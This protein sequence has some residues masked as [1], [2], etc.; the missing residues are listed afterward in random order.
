MGD[1]S[2]EARKVVALIVAAGSSQRF[3][4]DKLW[5]PVAGQPLLAHTL[6][7]FEGCPEIDEVVLVLSPQKVEAGRR[8]AEAGR[9]TKVKA[10]CAGGSCR[11]ESVAAGLA[12]AKDAGWVVVHDGARPCVT[13][14]I[15]GRGLF[16]AR[17]TGAAIAGVPVTDTIKVVGQE[18]QVKATPQRKELWSIQTPQVFRYDLLV[19]AYGRFGPGEDITDDATLVERLGHPVAVFWGA[20]SN[21]K[22]TT[23]HDIAVAEALLRPPRHAGLASGYVGLGYDVHPLVAGRRLVL[24]G[25]DIPFALGLAGHSDA[26]VLTH[27]IMDALLGA[28]ALGDIGQHFPAS[29]PQYKDISSLELARRVASKLQASCWR[30]GNIDAV[31]VAQEPG[32]SPYLAQ[33]RERLAS[34]LGI[35]PGQISLKAKHPEGLG[36]AGRGEGMATHAVAWVERA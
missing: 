24:G 29:D 4:R 1:A 21:I 25:V 18:G 12:Q 17:Q 2:Q 5:E 34:A 32:L 6:D 10:V 23:P 26:D 3:G 28:A 15:I 35:A 36:F 13:P 14:E 9:W 11:S 7:A 27:A 19:Q 22:V 31:I 33:M 8:W 20:Y 30:I 16:A